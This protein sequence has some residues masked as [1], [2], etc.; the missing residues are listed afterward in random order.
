MRALVLS[1]GGVKRAFQLGVLDELYAQHGVKYDYISGVSTGA[2]SGALLAHGDTFDAQQDALRVL[3]KI[4]NDIKGNDSI[5]RGGSNWFTK[6]IGIIKRGGMY[7]PSPLA[8]LVRKHVKPGPLSVS[9]TVLNVGYVNLD[10]GAYLV[11]DNKSSY[12]IEAILASAYQPIF[13]QLFGPL[14]DGGL[15][16]MTPLSECIKWAKGM[17]LENITI[18]VIVTSP[19]GAMNTK[20]INWRN[21]IEVL[22][23]TFEIIM[24][25]AFISDINT[26]NKLNALAGL[27][28]RVIKVKVNLYAPEY[29]L[30][31]GLEFN[32]KAIQSMITHGRLVAS[33]RTV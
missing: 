6:A 30:G 33:E 9:S 24:N 2:L 21:G 8:E 29:P 25:E 10:T 13:F 32:P 17:N 19:T 16:N 14:A 4:Y 7:D 27:N 12:I 20:A 3:F 11:A 23:R 5:Y 31:N 1:G 18:D 15:R 26:A 22:G 28:G